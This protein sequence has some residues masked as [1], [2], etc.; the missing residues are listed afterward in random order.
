MTTLADATLALAEIAQYAMRGTATGGSATTLI[1]TARTEPNDQF[2]NGTIWLLSGNNIGKS[3]IITSWDL[4]THTFTFAILTLLCAAGDLYAA[5]SQDYPKSALIQSIN[6]VLRNTFLPQ[7]DITLVTVA[8]QEEYALPTGVSDVRR[9]EIAQSDA[10]PYD[11]LESRNWTETN[12]KLVF[13]TDSAPGTASMK[14]RIT[15]AK[16]HAILSTD[17]GVVD[18]R[19]N[20]DWLVWHAAA[21]IFRMR[22]RKTEGREP[23]IIALYN[24]AVN[25]ARQQ[26]HPPF[27]PTESHLAGV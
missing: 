27:V 22:M 11:Y 7:V 24:D 8:D 23:Y 2:T 20:T 25:N 15:W 16:P 13:D 21:D 18:A 14:I 5:V 19:I 10:T 17:T 1:D 26:I 6:Q 3:A 9:V 4:A 12:G